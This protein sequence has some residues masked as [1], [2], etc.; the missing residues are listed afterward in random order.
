MDPCQSTVTKL[1][2]CDDDDF[3]RIPLRRP[4]WLNK[5][6]LWSITQRLNVSRYGLS[7]YEMTDKRWIV[8]PVLRQYRIAPGYPPSPM[9]SVA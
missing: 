9:L 1:P 5:R 8:P 2:V 4:K 3:D 7:F 6:Q